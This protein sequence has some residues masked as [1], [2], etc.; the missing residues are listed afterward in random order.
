MIERALLLTS[1]LIGFWGVMA[2]TGTSSRRY[3][4][5]HHQRRGSDPFHREGGRI[6]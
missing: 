2:K 5:E 4:L 1:F 6:R 3:R